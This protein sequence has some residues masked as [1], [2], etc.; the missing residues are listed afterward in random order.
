MPESVDKIKVIDKKRE[1][2][3]LVKHKGVVIDF[4]FEKDS[5]IKKRINPILLNVLQ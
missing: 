1:D 3:I 2:H 5:K 4:W